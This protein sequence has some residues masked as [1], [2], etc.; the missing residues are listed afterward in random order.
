MTKNKPL[1][2]AKYLIL[3]V[4]FTIA[5][6]CYKLEQTFPLATYAMIKDSAFNI[7]LSALLVLVFL[8]F[9]SSKK[10]TALLFFLGITFIPISEL[11]ITCGQQAVEI[12]GISPW[13]YVPPLFNF[14]DVYGIF[15]V[16]LLY[17]SFTL[18]QR[19]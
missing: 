3:A 10:Y 8:W 15:T 6:I 1:G 12:Q 9:K 5:F 16:T 2:L 19:E 7:V 11:I 4:A 18:S 13:W 17:F 14:I